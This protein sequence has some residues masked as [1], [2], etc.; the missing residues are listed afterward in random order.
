LPAYGGHATMVQ[1]V[2][3]TRSQLPDLPTDWETPSTSLAACSR[4]C[5]SPRCSWSCFPRC[6]ACSLMST[7]RSRWVCG[8]Y[9]RVKSNAGQDRWGGGGVVQVGCKSAVLYALGDCQ[10]LVVRY[11]PCHAH[12]SLDC[13]T[14]ALR[15]CPWPGGCGAASHAAPGPRPHRH[16]VR[17]AGGAGRG[18]QGAEQSSGNHCISWLRQ[19]VP[20]DL[21]LVEQ[22][23]LQRHFVDLDL[24][25]PASAAP[26]SCLFLSPTPSHFRPLPSLS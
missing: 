7:S 4:R 16:P 22:A 13:S 14:L 15:P 11:R 21:L 25:L 24:C 26:R 5:S 23:C 18:P 12:P 6:W 19:L 2:P 1:S 17:R 10:C 3:C 9:R 20:Y 8:C